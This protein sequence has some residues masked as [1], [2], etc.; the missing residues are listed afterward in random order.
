[1]SAIKATPIIPNR[2]S[3]RYGDWST[4]RP[5]VKDFVEKNITLCKPASVHVCDG[6]KEENDMLLNKLVEQERLIKLTKYD[7]W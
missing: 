5:Y 7:N 6:S 2:C 1:M 4:L 3:A